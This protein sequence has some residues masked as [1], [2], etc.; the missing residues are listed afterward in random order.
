MLTLL[1]PVLAGLAVVLT[2]VWRRKLPAPY[3]PGPPPK[4]FIG[5][6]AEILSEMKWVKYLEWSKRLNSDIIHMSCM[7][8]HIVVLHKLE[9]ITELMEKR[10]AIYSSRPWIPAA[11]M[12]GIDYVTG[13][14][15]YGEKFRRHRTIYHECLRKELMPLY[16]TTHTEIVHSAVDRLLS[17]PG[18]FRSHCK[19]LGIAVIMSTTFG[20]NIT[21]READDRYATLAAQVLTVISLL[22]Q[23]GGTLVNMIPFLRFVLPWIPGASTQRLA[24]NAKEAS[25]AYKTETYE[26]TAENCLKLAGTSND[27]ILTRLLRHHLKD[28]GITF[29]GED[30][31]KE[32]I[33]NIYLGAPYPLSAVLF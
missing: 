7:N 27:C 14:I 25:I 6:A 26:N 10:S 19:W 8:N 18:G 5:N 20:Y 30:D 3:P 4:P 2:L 31:L 23:P 15:P 1:L 13:L 28:D 12:L 22:L 11:E 16:Q 33:A 9:D 32:T 21:L 17:D 24:A 29:E